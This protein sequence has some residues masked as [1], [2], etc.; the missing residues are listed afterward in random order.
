MALSGSNAVRGSPVR[1]LW[2]PLRSATREHA[3]IRF[4][5]RLLN[6]ATEA[7]ALGRRIRSDGGRFHSVFLR[8]W[9]Q[10]RITFRLREIVDESG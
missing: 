7:D 4:G 6:G 2:A 5:E 10:F 9:D 3:S 8:C 1:R